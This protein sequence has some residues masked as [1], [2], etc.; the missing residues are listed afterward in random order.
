MYYRLFSFAFIILFGSIQNISA[1]ENFYEIFNGA[2][3]FRLEKEPVIRIGLATSANS[4]SITTT[5]SSLVAVSPDEPQKFLETAKV[6]VSARAYRPP[7]IEI[8]HFEIPNIETQTE[9]ADLAKDVQAAMGE[10][11]YA[12]IDSKTNIWRVVV[13]RTFDTVEEADDFKA[14]LSDKGFVADMITE[15]V[16]Q[17]SDEAVKLSN[18]V[19]KNPKSEVRSILPTHPNADPNKVKAI[20]SSSPVIADTVNPESARSYRQRRGRKRQI[21]VSQIRCVR[22]D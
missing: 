21:F 9:A 5:D 4:V 20:V 14:E 16:T 15:K 8:Y 17:P 12:L 18:Q 11:S 2:S 13:P 7:E 1:Y 10:N 3:V 19:A 6:T 22:F